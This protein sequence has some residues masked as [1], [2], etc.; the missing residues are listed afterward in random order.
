MTE[1]TLAPVW[2]TI[3]QNHLLPLVPAVILLA[4]SVGL[5]VIGRYR[6]AARL[7]VAVA[8]FTGVFAAGLDPFLHLWDE[9]FHALVASHLAQHPLHPLL[10]T[11]TPYPV[12][13][14]MWTHGTLWLH[15][16]PLFLW[17]MALFMKLMGT[18][19]WAVRLP[20]V[21]L[22]SFV[23]LMVFS[24]G[25]FFVNERV[26]W[27]A[28]LLGSMSF[29]I[30][31]LIS[32]HFATDHNDVVF[33]VYVTGSLWAWT[34]YFR[35]ASWQRAIGVGLFA[36]AA[37]LVK[38]LPGLLVFSG[39]G[40]WLLTHEQRREPRFWGH[41][42]VAF[43]VSIALALP[44]QVYTLTLFPSEAWYE[45][46]YNARHFHE[47]IEEHGG[48]W[49]FHFKAIEDLYGS[50]DAMI[51]I[52]VTAF[53]L[54]PFW[55]RRDA[56]VAPLT[57]VIV[58]YIVFTLATTKMKAFCLP[59]APVLWISLAALADKLLALIPPTTL[60]FW[61][62]LRRGA[63]FGV[64]LLVAFLMLNINEMA[65][66][67]FVPDS[68]EWSNRQQQLRLNTLL[69][70]LKTDLANNDSIMIFTN[71]TYQGAAMSYMTGCNVF[72]FVPSPMLVE[73]LI[74]KGRE[75]WLINR[76]TPA[77]HLATDQRIRIIVVE[78]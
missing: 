19:V 18:T 76:G 40:V 16:Q 26:G 7:L 29:F 20:S 66:T 36:G 30:Y 28:A 42:L 39:W 6:L 78:E 72:G 12:E 52:V 27:I 44:W 37:V 14:G 50:G 8:F 75:I 38:W 45:L 22:F 2:F 15:K 32:G 21:I 35:R 41:L 62:W 54:L 55:A 25:R 10:Y 1:G 49:F 74:R 61:K 65:R 58:L 9:Q 71:Y 59:A 64:W 51:A 11:E 4:A 69:H 17:Q 53:A 70:T 48:D 68:A 31:E 43:L 56:V 5:A 63:S 47:V 46:T 23:S 67:R 24:M 34:Y 60:Q 73:D 57:W 13:P 3:P 77:A 33:M